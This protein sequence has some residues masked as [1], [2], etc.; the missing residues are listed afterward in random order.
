MKAQHRNTGNQDHLSHY[1]SSG[2][3]LTSNKFVCKTGAAVYP[4]SLFLHL[5]VCYQF[6]SWSRI[7]TSG[8]TADVAYVIIE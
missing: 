1:F 6:M 3:N 2:R 8:F 5:T 7:A 4:H